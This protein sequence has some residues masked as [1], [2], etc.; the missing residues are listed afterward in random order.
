MTYK[1]GQILISTEELELEKALSGEKVIIPKGNEVIIGGDNF[2]HH[3]RSNI[4]QVLPIDAVI[5]GYDCEGL[6]DYI[7]RK[8]KAMYPLSE[9]L[10]DYEID[11]KDFT[12]DIEYILSEIF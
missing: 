7:V 3:I 9:M 12:D 6:A 2:A 4:I 5:E 11:E 10:E 8:L 1:I